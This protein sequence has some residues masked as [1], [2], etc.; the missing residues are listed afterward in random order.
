MQAGLWSGCIF[1]VSIAAIALYGDHK[2]KNRRDLNRV[3]FMP[4]PLVLVLS[5]TTAVVLAAF[6]LKIPS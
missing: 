1:A 3:G 6:A 2:R 5:I 4:W